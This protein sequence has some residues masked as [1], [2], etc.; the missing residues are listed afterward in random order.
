MQ[1]TPNLK[2]FFMLSL[3]FRCPSG[4]PK[5]FALA[6]CVVSLAWGSVSTA[7]AGASDADMSARGW[8]L[9]DLTQQML[10]NNPQLL[11]AR[12]AARATRLGVQPAQAPDNPTIGITQDPVSRN[13]LAWNT[14][15]GASWTVSQNIYWPG[16]KS[17]AGEVV[18][19]QASAAEAQADGVQ[20]QLLGQLRSAWLAW[21][22]SQSQLQITQTQL[23]RLEQIKQITKV[24]YANNAAAFADYINAQV[25]QEQLR[26][27][28]LTTR[29]QADTLMAQ[30]AALVGKPTVTALPL[31]A[32]VL[33]R[34]QDVP[35]LGSFR[36]AALQRNPQIKAAEASVRAA[37][38]GVDLAELSSRPDFNV[39]LTGHAANP[40]WGLGNTPT[41]GVSVGMTVPLWY[42]Q[43]EKWLQDQAKALLASV[44][45]ADESQRQQTL[46]AVDTAWLQWSQNLEQLRLLE[47]VLME[48]ARTAY[49]LALGNYSAG[50]VPYVDVL[51]AFN[52]ERSVELSV[53]QARSSALAARVALDAAVGET[54]VPVLP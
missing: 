20:S 1:K 4:S 12:H 24:R 32:E 31:R 48:Q 41:Y 22:T 50:Q 37:Q 29:M 7:V 33:V 35:A 11:S 26:T 46:L 19:A 25:T 53:V 52:T 2:E 38:R 16:K 49:R 43:K 44:R 47:G 9:S 27:T 42:S 15:Q 23:E 3:F 40:P 14:S 30:I 5:A 8:S 34:Q 45:D 17:L 10:D 36:E 51:N 6:L 28:L 21:Q 18:S 39:A 54:S 13:P